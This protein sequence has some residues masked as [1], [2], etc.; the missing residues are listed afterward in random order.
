MARITQIRN[1]IF[2]SIRL[3][4]IIRGKNSLEMSLWL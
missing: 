2:Q 4:R 3:I 1:L